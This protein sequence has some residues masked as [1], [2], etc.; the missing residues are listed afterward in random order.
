MYGRLR[1]PGTRPCPTEEGEGALSMDDEG[2]SA[3]ATRPK[4]VTSQQGKQFQLP[5]EVQELD[6][7]SDTNTNFAVFADLP[8]LE[9]PSEP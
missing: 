9:M 6:L 5:R 3:C 4:S 8:V 1:T 7:T 2:A